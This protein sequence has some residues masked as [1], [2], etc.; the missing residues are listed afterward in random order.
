MAV[1]QL[2][3]IQENAVEKADKNSRSFELYHY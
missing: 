3:R 1:N 2:T